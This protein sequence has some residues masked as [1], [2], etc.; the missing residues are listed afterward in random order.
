MRTN[1]GG[2]LPVIGFYEMK[3]DVYDIARRLK[4][5]DSVRQQRI[6]FCTKYIPVLKMIDTDPGLKE[7]CADHSVYK[8]DSKHGSL[9]H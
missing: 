5:Q 8:N 9:I 1:M 6:D 4:M 3:Q 7:A 2:G